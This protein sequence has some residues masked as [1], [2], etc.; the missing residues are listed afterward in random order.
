MHK[1]VKEWLKNLWR[2][3][4]FWLQTIT[5]LR[6]DWV[7]LKNS[8]TSDAGGD[9]YKQPACGSAQEEAGANKDAWRRMQRW[10]SACRGGMDVSIHQRAPFPDRRSRR[11]AGG[12]DDLPPFIWLPGRA[13]GSGP[14]YDESV[15]VTVCQLRPSRWGPET[16]MSTYQ[17]SLPNVLTEG[18][19]EKGCGA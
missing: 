4:F 7:S 19:W 3:K 2:Q 1:W 5:R 16:N 9:F 17:T 11:R 13:D 15:C 10:A 8:L 14:A 18:K 6:T 12:P